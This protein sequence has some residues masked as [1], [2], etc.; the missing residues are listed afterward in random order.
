MS[1][2]FPL[3]RIA[4]SPIIPSV[5][6]NVTDTVLTCF[7]PKEERDGDPA[8]QPA[9]LRNA[10]YNDVNGDARFATKCDNPYDFL[11]LV[12]CNAVTVFLDNMLE[13]DL[14]VFRIFEDYISQLVSYRAN[15]IS[16]GHLVLIPLPDRG[17]NR[18]F[19]EIS[20]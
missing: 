12:V 3:N 18:V 19:Q 17:A 6:I 15:I 1:K 9:D 14:Q 2:V 11:A 5:L 10:I 16:L 20:R 8:F 13:K 7:T 4:R